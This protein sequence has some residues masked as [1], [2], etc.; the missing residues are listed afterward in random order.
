MYVYSYIYI[1]C[2]IV[3]ILLD[4]KLSNV[5]MYNYAIIMKKKK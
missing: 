2:I 3:L 4:H 1:L 5:I